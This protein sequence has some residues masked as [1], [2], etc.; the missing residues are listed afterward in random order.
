MDV[1]QLQQRLWEAA[2]NATADE[3][4]PPDFPGRVMRQLRREIHRE[5]TPVLAS[6]WWRAATW[7]SA[8]AVLVFATAVAIQL[9]SGPDLDRGFQN[10]LW[11]A[12]DTEYEALEMQ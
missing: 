3:T 5:W 1:G 4:V 2:R 8:V 12:I 11:V 6:R 9:R 7:C 10:V